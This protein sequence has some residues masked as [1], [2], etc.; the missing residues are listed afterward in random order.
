LRDD[1]NDSNEVKTTSITPPRQ[2]C[3]MDMWSAA[4]TRTHSSCVQSADEAAGI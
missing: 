4:S 2:V 3:G 1:S